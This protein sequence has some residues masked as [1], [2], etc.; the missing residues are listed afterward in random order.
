MILVVVLGFLQ[1]R[2]LHQPERGC[3][4]RWI[5]Y[6]GCTSY[7]SGRSQTP[8]HMLWEGPFWK[9]DWGTGIHILSVL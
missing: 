9:R 3:S 4:F 6:L 5:I 8:L 2:L 7:K 1:S